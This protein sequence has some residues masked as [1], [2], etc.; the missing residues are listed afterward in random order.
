MVF[1]LSIQKDYSKWAVYGRGKV[2][3][4]AVGVSQRY[5]KEVKKELPTKKTTLSP[6]GDGAL[7]S[8]HKSKTSEPPKPPT[9]KH[10][11]F[12]R[13]SWGFYVDRLRV[14][15][16]KF[17]K[18]YGAKNLSL[19]KRIVEELATGDMGEVRRRYLNLVHWSSAKPDFFT[20][21]PGCMSSQWERLVDAPK[22]GD[23]KESIYPELA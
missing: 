8:D 21:T 16:D 15:S 11:D 12:H 3:T 7:D 10:K 14:H 6:S 13:L 5:I 2:P 1:S 22:G 17:Y 19:C 4:T 23:A 18:P 20:L 9:E